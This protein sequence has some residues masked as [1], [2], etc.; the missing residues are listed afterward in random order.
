MANLL[1]IKT[2]WRPIDEMIGVHKIRKFKFKLQNDIHLRELLK[3]GG[4]FF[5]IRTLGFIIIYIFALFVTR[6]LGASAWGVFT[7]YL[8][9]LQIMAVFAKLGLD[10]ALLRF[11]AQYNAQNKG[12]TVINIYLKSVALIIPFSVFLSV[13]LFFLSSILAEKIFAKEYLAYY[14][15]L[16]SFSL[17]PFVLLYINSESL[18]AFKRIKEYVFFQTLFP[19]LIAFVLTLTF[20]A[21]FKNKNINH[22][23]FAYVL[24]INFSFLLSTVFVVKDF[25][26]IKGEKEVVSLKHILSVSFPMLVSSSLFMIMFWADT[27]MLSIWKT[28]EEVG[29]YNV[30]VRL[31][32]IASFPLIAINSI[33]APKFAELWGKG[34]IEGLKRLAQQ[35]TELIFWLSAP[36]LTL[37]LIIPDWFMGLFGEEFRR[38][39]ISLIYLTIGQFV[40][41][42]SGS[43]GYILMMIGYEKFHQ[44]IILGTVLLN[45]ILNWILIPIYGMVGAALASATSVVTWNLVFTIKTKQVLHEFIFY[46]LWK[47]K[48]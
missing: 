40:N 26:N 6:R 30:A 33:A 37:Y 11:I 5:I 23:I 3:G 44:Y 38:G 32:M 39:S 16:V 36:I 31:S 43:V 2:L 15:K 28:E 20:W 42:A 8:T 29:I 45:I 27:I 4:I 35:S 24:G 14:I 17:L 21:F 46:P 9:L 19:F 1:D 48:L 41:A 7:F 47:L 10:T 13:N 18:R 22:V 34:D 12:K 25:K